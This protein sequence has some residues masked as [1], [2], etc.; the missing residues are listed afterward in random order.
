[1]P[2]THWTFLCGAIALAGLPPLSGFWSKD[3]IIA[4]VSSAADVSTHATFFHVV[5]AIALA[6]SLLTAFYT[7]RAYFMTFWGEQRFPAE[8]GHHPHEATPV[9]AWPL[10]ILAVGAVLV[11][12]VF[13]PTE[14]FAGYMHHSRGHVAV[15][16]QGLHYGV[17]LSST[18][19]GLLGAA[20][21]WLFYVRSPQNAGAARPQARP[22]L[23][24]LAG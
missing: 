1:M 9:M 4:V 16:P 10:R 12:I 15:E 3:E 8:A 22:A 21:A 7:F 17:L 20:L 6:T 19:V 13:G 14:M 11:G 24:A 18:A 2:I 5:F 23:H